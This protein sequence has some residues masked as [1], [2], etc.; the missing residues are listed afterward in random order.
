MTAA[1]TSTIRASTSS[2]QLTAG[3]GTQPAAEPRNATV[4]RTTS[5]RAA[6]DPTASNRRATGCPGA[7]Q[8][9]D[10]PAR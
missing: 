4:N 9:S 1:T 6:H 7:F 10:S 2:G 8:H 3:P 5:P